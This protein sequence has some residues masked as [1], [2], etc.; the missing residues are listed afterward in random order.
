MEMGKAANYENELGTELRLGLPGTD[1]EA[2]KQSSP[3]SLLINKSNKR[4]SSEMDN[5]SDKC[6]QDSAPAPK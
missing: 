3:T 2:E 5:S 1:R 4:S 6:D